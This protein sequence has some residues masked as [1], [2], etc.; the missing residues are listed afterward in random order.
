MKDGIVFVWYEPWEVCMLFC[1]F[2]K[3]VID[4]LTILLRVL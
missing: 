4:C 1:L 3:I 2:E